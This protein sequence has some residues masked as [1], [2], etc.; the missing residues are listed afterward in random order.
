MAALLT[1]EHLLVRPGDLTRVNIAFF[2]IN[3]IIS[4]G[5]FVVGA[6]DLLT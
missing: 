2:N 6:V 3:A 5:L 1:Y 4:I